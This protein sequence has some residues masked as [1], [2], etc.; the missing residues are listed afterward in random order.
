MLRE[1]VSQIE[2]SLK[3]QLGV[4]MNVKLPPSTFELSEGT[5]TVHFEGRHFVVKIETSGYGEHQWIRLKKMKCKLYFYEGSHEVWVKELQRFAGPFE[6]EW[7]PDW[8]GGFLCF[9]L[10]E[11]AVE[12]LSINA[13]H[14]RNNIPEC[15]YDDPQHPSNLRGLGKGIKYGIPAE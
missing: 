1:I 7:K 3:L 4:P 5:A 11:I 2:Q 9:S 6:W 13:S 8:N 12:R 10:S 15:G 14:R